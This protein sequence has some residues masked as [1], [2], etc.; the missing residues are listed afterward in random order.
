MAT[1]LDVRSSSNSVSEIKTPLPG[2]HPAATRT[3]PDCVSGYLPGW[4]RSRFGGPASAKQGTQE[5]RIALPVSFAQATRTAIYKNENDD[6]TFLERMA[7]GG[8]VC[9]LFDGVTIPKRNYRAGHAVSSFVR[10]FLR[11]HL[12]DRDGRRPVVETV[13]ANALQESV[14]VF[15]KLGG[16]AAT[17]ASVVVGVPMRD[18]DWRLYAVNAGNSRATI[19]APDGTLDPLTRVKPPGTPF[20]AL[21]TLSH[22]Y[23]YKLEST[24][25]TVPAGT[26]VLLTSDGVHDHIRDTEIWS[27]LGSATATVLGEA[28]K[29]PESGV[30]ERLARLFVERVVEQSTLAQE[31]VQ[32]P[33]DTTALA[34]L[35]GDPIDALAQKRPRAR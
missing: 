5:L 30:L 14:G 24:K 9:A 25:L 27:A 31:R 17:T 10:D 7:D 34:V 3:L 29:A 19:F 32:R 35:L 13:L 26:I 18:G 11:T 22:G 20:A 15:E 33:D 28:W 23:P 8:L 4:V 2:T 6:A 1:S 16:G 21:N 12:V